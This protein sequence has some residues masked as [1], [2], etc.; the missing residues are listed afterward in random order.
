LTG[1]RSGKADQMTTLAS[2]SAAL[3]RA[4][5][6]VAILLSVWDAYVEL[7]VIVVARA[8]GLFTRQPQGGMLK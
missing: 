2:Q 1:C 8:V 4:A 7:V 3:A 6:S 5:F